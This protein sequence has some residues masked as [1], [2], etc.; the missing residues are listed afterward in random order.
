M[1]KANKKRYVYAIRIERKFY[2]DDWEPDTVTE[3]VMDFPQYGSD[4]ME[5]VYTTLDAAN[6]DFDKLLKQIDFCDPDT[7]DWR[8]INKKTDEVVECK[9]PSALHVRR[10]EVYAPL[11]DID[12]SSVPVLTLDIT[13]VELI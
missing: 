7:K 12:D 6:A 13:K 3:V 4:W 2:N 5:R 1:S 11:G 10:V 8:K 9:P